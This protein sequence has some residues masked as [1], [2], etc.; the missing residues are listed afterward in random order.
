MGENSLGISEESK[1]NK[2]SDYAV[3]PPEKMKKQHY[4]KELTLSL[5]SCYWPSS[6]PLQDVW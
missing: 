2:K 6:V 1:S 3:S 4:S 5:G